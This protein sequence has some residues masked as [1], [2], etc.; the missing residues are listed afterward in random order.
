MLNFVLLSN[1]NIQK[2]KP[3]LLFYLIHNNM[4]LYESFFSYTKKRKTLKVHSKIY[5]IT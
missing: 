1:I 3:S 2:L 4:E 5:E